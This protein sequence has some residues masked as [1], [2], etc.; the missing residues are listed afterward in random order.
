MC[1]VHV[2]LVFCSDW[3]SLLIFS[4]WLFVAHCCIVSAGVSIL[5][6]ASMPSTSAGRCHCPAAGSVDS[7]SCVPFGDV[8]N[9]VVVPADESCYDEVV[10]ATGSDVC[11]FG[12]SPSKTCQK[13][14]KCAGLRQY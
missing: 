11:E 8:A 6:G 5:T 12:A 1:I 10:E 9:S 14:G 4:G 13:Q 2:L 3:W 7:M